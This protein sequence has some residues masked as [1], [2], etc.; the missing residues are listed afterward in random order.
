MKKKG[1]FYFGTASKKVNPEIGD[2][3]QT[4]AEHFNHIFQE[5][6]VQLQPL[7][8]E[9]IYGVIFVVNFHP[10]YLK[11]VESNPD[12]LAIRDYKMRPCKRMLLKVG[13]IDPGIHGIGL[14]HERE[15]G[16]GDARK[17]MVGREAFNYEVQEQQRV[18][19]MTNNHLQPITPLIY[20]NRVYNTE[21]SKNFLEMLHKN[22]SR[23]AKTKLEGI[24]NLFTQNRNL[25]LG[26]I[27]MEM[28]DGFGTVGDAVRKDPSLVDNVTFLAMTGEVL[29]RLHN[30]CKVTHGDLHM[31]NLLIE[32]TKKSYYG[33]EIG[34]ILLID[35][36]RAQI[37]ARGVQGTQ[38][39]PIPVNEAQI[40]LQASDP[41]WPSYQWLSPQKL[42]WNS[43]NV[44]EK[45]IQLRELRKQNYITS[46]EK[47]PAYFYQPSALTFW[48]SVRQDA[49]N[50]AV[51]R[52]EKYQNKKSKNNKSKRKN[53]KR[54]SKRQSRK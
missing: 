33:P 29:N 10:E 19:N 54:Q 37:H 53:S 25:N 14:E 17:Q 7:G 41:N 26:F 48:G 50:I 23:E 6:I 44:N 22:S 20:Y 8:S 46:P 12:L 5:G 38:D 30:I 3:K 34:N 4:L 45:C 2:E 13:Y 49:G 16:H 31:G 36:G 40:E 11:N 52:G 43:D 35:W 51:K 42:R 28:R 15:I 32:T 24:A 39:R 27:F 47:L 18:F 21:G 1:G 9:G